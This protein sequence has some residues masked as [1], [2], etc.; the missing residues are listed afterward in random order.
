[1]RIIFRIARLELSILFYS[2]IAWLILAVFIF[3]AGLQFSDLVLRHEAAQQ[4]GTR[5]PSL[6]FRIFADRQYNGVFHE[7]Q[8]KLFLYIPLLTMG[9]V[10]R[11]ISSGSIKL[12]LSSPV[13]T[14][15]IVLG[16]FL[17]MTGYAFLL[18]FLASCI[19]LA[20][21]IAIESLDYKFMLSGLLGIFLVICAY[22]AIGLFMSCLTSYQVVAAIST[23]V[24]LS[25][26]NYVGKIGQDIDLVR[27]I[28][29]FLSIAGRSNQIISGLVSSKDVLYYAI[30]TGMF[31]G[32]SMLNLQAARES[33]PFWVKAGRY[34]LLIAACLTT[35]Y[36]TSRPA[37]TLYYDMTVHKSRT[38]TP[39]SREIVKNVKEPLQIT[40]YGNVL[41]RYFYMVTPKQQNFDMQQYEL[42]TRFLPDMK[43]SY[44]HY[45]DTVPNKSLFTNNK[46]LSL[47]ELAK[48]VARSR[49]MDFDRLLP[50]AEIRQQADLAPEENRLVRQVSLNGKTSFI[51]T[52]DDILHYPSEAEISAAIKRLQHPPVKVA[53][54]QG[55]GERDFARA[56]DKDYKNAT[57]ELTFR[58]S[59]INQGFDVI[60]LN[61]AE[62]HIPA[63]VAAIV[64]ADPRAAYTS[65]EIGKLKDFL[66]AGGNMLIA[67]EPGRQ[68][69]LQ[70]VLDLLGVHFIPGQVVGNNKEYPP[71]F[72][73]ADIDTQAVILS[74]V[75]EKLLEDRIKVSLS[76]A[77]GL[78]YDEN[79]SYKVMPL[80]FNN[81][82]D[83]W[84]KAGKYNDD[85]THVSF[86][87]EAGDRR[88]TFPVALAL[89]R[90]VK[91][92]AQ[93]IMILG[94]A[95]LMNNVELARAKPRVANFYFSIYTFKWLSNDVYPVNTDRPEPPDRKFKVSRAGV[96]TLKYLLLGAIPALIFGAGAWTLVR[97]KRS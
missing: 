25:V 93:R 3:Q 88:G 91:G 80:L 39:A 43:L 9:L 38:L 60:G 78:Q 54:L 19:V 49:N 37:F 84:N 57:T 13:R 1:M 87:A 2:P 47:E 41:D 29:Y 96:Q 63:G 40:T 48:K 35:G 64:V 23:L 71:N 95:D 65:A 86:L 31:L 50:P 97:R 7:I 79:G 69:L 74:P 30:V 55:R 14:S 82:A 20:G 70:P 22:S 81:P 92:K 67:G 10:S 73:F 15:E 4:I 90:D 36:I 61:L 42:Y 27:D 34:A 8:S 12:L 46:G 21:G 62:Q 66:D 52:F 85:S 75:F 76:G 51:R 56:G 83:T 17:A 94:D 77:S 68:E 11:E 6:S 26:L 32:F 18:V 58:Y 53:F 44:V 45:Y 24:V 33:K 28:T 89:S 59:L 72:I 16:K 5:L